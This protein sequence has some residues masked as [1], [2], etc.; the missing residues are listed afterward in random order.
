MDLGRTYRGSPF[1]GGGVH[2]VMRSHV[3]FSP[4]GALARAILGR[5]I[6]LRASATDIATRRPVARRASRVPSLTAH[7]GR[8]HARMIDTE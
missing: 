5:G 8:A 3:T 4:V 7:V 1:G 6:A 2:G